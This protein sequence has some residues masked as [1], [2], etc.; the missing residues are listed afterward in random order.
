MP[1]FSFAG[2]DA[3]SRAYPPDPAPLPRARPPVLRRDGLSARPDGPALDLQLCRAVS[4]SDFR[5]DLD[6]RRNRAPRVPVHRHVGPRGVQAR[7]NPVR[8]HGL[9]H[10]P[11]GWNPPAQ[12]DDRSIPPTRAGR[13]PPGDSGSPPRNRYPRDRHG[14]R[15]GQDLLRPRPPEG[16]AGDH[17]PDADPADDAG[18]PLA[19]LEPRGVEPRLFA[20][21]ELERAGPPVLLAVHPVAA[22]GDVEPHRRL[23]D[24]AGPELAGVVRQRPPH[25]VGP[26]VLPPPDRED[27]LKP[28]IVDGLLQPPI[29]RVE[30]V[31]DIIEIEAG[32]ACVRIAPRVAVVPPE[33][34]EAAVGVRDG[35]AGPIE[36]PA[37]PVRDPV[38]LPVRGLDRIRRL[39]DRHVL[40][41]PPELP[42]PLRAD[43]E[44]VRFA[45]VRF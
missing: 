6:P 26:R 25:L 42:R 37:V 36:R 31:E 14:G 2:Y 11:Q 12:R 35:I 22:E 3:S 23:E 43:E 13:P 34:V 29:H 44:A 1:P 38:H 41:G 9:P 33:E 32:E 19:G 28:P 10:R 4:R 20:A 40:R 15:H 24:D 45:V 7:V 27:K 8:D 17:E 16:R 18:E 5:T 21:R 39:Q 30:L